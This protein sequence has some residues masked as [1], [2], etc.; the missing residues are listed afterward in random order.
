[1]G[2]YHF[3]ILPEFNNS[4]FNRQRWCKASAEKSQHPDSNSCELPARPSGLGNPVQSWSINN[5]LSFLLTQS[6]ASSMTETQ[7]P[8]TQHASSST[9]LWRPKPQAN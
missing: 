7:S 6:G 9:A 3:P 1:M 4:I 2:S 5:H 8:T